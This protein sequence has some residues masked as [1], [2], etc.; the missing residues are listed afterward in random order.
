MSRRKSQVSATFFQYILK[1]CHVRTNAT[2]CRIR[3]VHDFDIKKLFEFRYKQILGPFWNIILKNSVFR[4]IFLKYRII[5]RRQDKYHVLQNI[6]CKTPMILILKIYRKLSV[7][8]YIFYLIF[9]ERTRLRCA[10]ASLGSER[11]ASA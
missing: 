10:S 5:L 11:C 4:N 6:K 2:S 1:S 3:N 9:Q 7:I 8:K